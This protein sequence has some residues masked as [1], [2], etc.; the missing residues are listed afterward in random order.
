MLSTLNNY[1]H[2]YY[3]Y[4]RRAASSA[5]LVETLKTQY[6]FFF[7]SPIS[8][9]AAQ[10][11]LK[12]AQRNQR[13]PKEPKG[14]LKF[15]KFL[16]SLKFLK[17]LKSL[18]P[19]APSPQPPAPSLYPRLGATAF[20]PCQFQLANLDQYEEQFFNPVWAALKS[21]VNYLGL[22]A[23]TQINVIDYS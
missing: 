23:I 9:V 20:Q 8:H 2:K 1:I 5:L 17:C 3:F 11:V 4:A 19:R 18:K 16:K 22:V 21:S 15:L 12:K 10:N 6:T 13:S 7:L 14:F